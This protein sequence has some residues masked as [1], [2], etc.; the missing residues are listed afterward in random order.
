MPVA[1]AVV[2]ATPEL[3]SLTADLMMMAAGAGV[4]LG[5]LWASVVGR[6]SL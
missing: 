2:A 1:V 5:L 4:V 3:D 6:P